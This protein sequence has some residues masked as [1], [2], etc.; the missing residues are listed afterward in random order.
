[1]LMTIRIRKF[2]VFNFPSRM[3]GGEVSAYILF[4]EFSERTKESLEGRGR[5]WAP[6]LHGQRCFDSSFARRTAEGGCPDVARLSATQ[7]RIEVL[8][9]RRRGAAGFAAQ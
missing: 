2:R 8:L 6:S 4:L 9:P 5:A 7:W 1:M 3:D